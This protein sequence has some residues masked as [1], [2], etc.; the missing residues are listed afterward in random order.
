MESL[1][2][3]LSVYIPMDRRQALARG[4]SLPERA[5]GAVLFAD[6]SGF[7]PLTEAL[8]LE[9]G[10]QRGAEE[11]TYQLNRVYT[12][13]IAQVHAYRGS[14]I[15]FSGDAI[16]CWFDGDGASRA[17]SCASSM[18]QA[19]E[20]F[21]RV[22]TPAG[23]TVALAIKV[24]VTT[25]PVRRF[26]V[27]DP[28]IQLIDVLAGSTLDRMAAAEQVAGSGEIVAGMPAVE[29]MGSR[30]SI[31]AWRQ[32]SSG[33]RFAVINRPVSLATPT[34]WPE[35]PAQNLVETAV[36]SWLLKPVCNRL[37]TGQTQFLAEL[38]AAVA[39]F[40]KFDGLDYDHDEAVSDKLNVFICWVQS[41]LNHYEGTLL[42]LTTGDKGSYLYAALGAPVAHEDDI[43]R[44]I[45][46][47]LDLRALPPE[48]SFISQVKIGLSRGRMRTGAYGSDTRRTYG[49]LGDETNM[50]ARLMSQAQA[51][52]ILVTSHI[53]KSAGQS[54]QFSELGSAAIKGKQEPVPL[55]EL[56]GRRQTVG[57]KLSLGQKT[58]MVGRTRERRLLIEQLQALR[59]GGSSAVVIVEGEAGIGKSR[60]IVDLLEQARDLGIMNLVGSGDAIEKS[61]VYFA[62]NAIFRQIFDL[63][64]AIDPHTAQEQ[65][66][67]RLATLL[68]ELSDRAPLL[69]PVLSL[70]FPDNALTESMQGKVRADNTRDLLI[71]LLLGLAQGAPLLLVMEDAH[72]LDSASWALLQQAKL[73]VAPLLLVIVTR[74]MME[75]ESVMDTTP[76]EYQR[77]LTSPD[78][79]HLPLSALPLDETLTLVC[80]RLGVSSL[81][82][83]VAELVREKAGGHPFF[84]EELAYALRD[85]GILQIRGDQCFIAPEAGD[86][87]ALNF[88]DTIQGVVISRIDRL[89][90]QQQLVLKVASVIGRIFAY[91]LLRDVYPITTDRPELSSSINT[92]ARLDLTLLETPEPNLAYIFKHI[93]TQ[94]V[95]YNLMT[96]A[97]R[98]QLH[99]A[100][101]EWYEQ[102]HAD[103]LSPFFPVL[104]HHWSKAEVSRKAVEFLSKAGEQALINYANHEAIYFINQAISLAR[105]HVNKNGSQQAITPLQQA[106]WQHQLGEAYYGLGRLAE[107]EQHF[108]SALALLER[109]LPAAPSRLAFGLLKQLAKQTWYRLGATPANTEDDSSKTAQE[110]IHL[111]HHVYERLIEIAFLYSNPL[112]T[113]YSTVHGLNLAEQIGPSAELADGY[114]KMCLAFGLIPAHRLA[115]LYQRLATETLRRV[116][117]PIATGNVL[118]SLSVYTAG[119]GQ[120]EQTQAG[121]N[122]SLELFERFGNWARWGICMELLC[123]V[124]SYQGRFAAMSDRYQRLLGVAQHRDDAV[125]QVWGLNGQ[126][127]SNIV[128]GD[129]PGE[130]VDLANRALFL[131]EQS[132]EPD[133]RI[134][135]YSFL[136]LAQLACGQWQQAQAAAAEALAAIVQAQPTSF[137]MFE[138]YA[139]TAAT[140]LALWERQTDDLYLKKQASLANKALKSFARRFPIGRPRSLL[141]QG[142]SIWLAGQVDKAHKLWQEALAAS[143]QLQMPYELGLSHYEIGRHLTGDDPAR[144]QH[145][146]QAVA[147]FSRLGATRQQVQAKAVLDGVQN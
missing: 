41:I 89:A 44:A 119:I 75:S 146:T 116:E 58:E 27:G 105:Q 22:I 91:Y 15:G 45:A 1:V 69:N 54:F 62:W 85:A 40:L 14:V 31:A 121:L 134:K 87:R 113:I 130:A 137:G 97:Q 77:F 55:F 67:A 30:L 79:L 65:V 104:A 103:E 68:P 86:L 64:E 141:Y 48:M 25:G 139:S 9:L 39:L 5:T 74:P 76:P 6:I 122:R 114:S 127:L 28:Q 21:A 32:D 107:S 83:P 81:P 35:I 16:T 92:L 38:R 66:Q 90:P 99:Q 80:R 110:A 61:T 53:V 95:A 52:Q 72:W 111:A 115:R 34:S 8:A 36:S 129:D 112:L 109:P 37:R 88:P 98:R 20:Q 43:D 145:L 26:V 126:M 71:R 47:A 63:S 106:R 17:L 133:A 138:A 93:I 117:D 42:Q 60:L 125:Q 140:W 84:S 94:E 50:A 96:F 70:D 11:L 49:V 57:Q 144:Q 123:L 2:E 46:T 101:A 108:R 100:V 19:M 120:W 135:T 59:D 33:R 51:N 4:E 10:E 12:A 24:A 7:M 147:I 18:Q 131:L 124:A 102:T 3:L 142:R 78:T 82:E 13:L 128:A 118:M 136:A 56:V 73:D 23:T 132:N 29:Q 143:E